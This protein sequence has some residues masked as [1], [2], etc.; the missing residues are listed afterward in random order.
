MFPWIVFRLQHGLSMEK[1]S[2]VTLLFLLI[3]IVL[4]HVQQL[5][6]AWRQ[7]AWQQQLSFVLV[8]ILDVVEQV[9]VV[10]E[11]FSS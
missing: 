5:S 3:S 1:K 4:R 2:N 10:V 9:E 11:A 6:G 8:L 7:G